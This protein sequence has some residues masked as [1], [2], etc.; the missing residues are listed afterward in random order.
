MNDNIET[1]KPIENCQSCGSELKGK[2]CSTCGEKKFNPQRDLSL[3]KFL[4]HSV[5]M[6]IHFDTKFFKTFKNL[7]FYPGTLTKDFITGRRVLYM[8]PMQ[9]FIL[10]SIIFYFLLPGT[11][12]YYASVYDFNGKFSLGNM[13]QYDSH[14]KLSV[15]KIKYNVNEE[16]IVNYLRIHTISSSKLFLFS[17]FPIWAFFLFAL[18]YKSNRFYVS[19]LVFSL[20]CFTFFILIHLLYLYVLSKYMKSIPLSYIVPLFIIFAFYLFFAIRKYYQQKILVSIV[21]CVVA[22]LSF[23]I[24]LELYRECVTII[25]LYYL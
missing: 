9:L 10:A 7:F 23:L 12:A 13:V 16:R 1:S 6:Y 22:C 15:K 25:N 3:I 21:K 19:H 5:D 17:I 4:E 8:K 20:H 2:F 11:D 18:F 14:N 24:L